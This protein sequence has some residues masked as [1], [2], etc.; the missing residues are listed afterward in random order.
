MTAV[1]RSISSSHSKSYKALPEGFMLGGLP[2]V[3]CIV[4]KPKA[5]EHDAGFGL[6]LF[7]EVAKLSIEKNYLNDALD[8]ILMYAKG[9]GLDK[10]SEFVAEQKQDQNHELLD[11]IYSFFRDKCPYFFERLN[12]FLSERGC[13]VVERRKQLLFL[14]TAKGLGFHFID[15]EFIRSVV[16]YTKTGLKTAKAALCQMLGVDSDGLTSI[17][18][19]LV[20]E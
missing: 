15:G 11:K 5:N 18:V 1:V 16:G 12:A 13:R 14:L 6:V 4:E 20:K 7:G 17:L 2:V 3:G 19:G 9:H 10:L 8:N